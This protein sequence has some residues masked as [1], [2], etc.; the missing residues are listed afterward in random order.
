MKISTL[1]SVTPLRLLAISVTFLSATRPH[2][3][4]ER[5]PLPHC[6][7]K[8]KT[9]KVALKQWCANPGLQ[10]ARETRLCKVVS[11]IF[12][13]SVWNLLNVNQLAPENLWWLLSC[14]EYLCTC[15]SSFRFEYCNIRRSVRGYRR[16]HECNV[17]LQRMK[18][19]NI[20]SSTFSQIHLS[21]VDA[22]FAFNVRSNHK[23]WYNTK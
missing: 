22:P 23:A 4:E 5:R 6:C 14:V 3:P 11:G 8:L 12:G 19:R 15:F 7:E 2:N 20:F 10:I 16:W 1:E 9:R 17:T 13:S 21:D 18:I